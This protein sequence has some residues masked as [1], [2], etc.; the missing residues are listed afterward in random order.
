MIDRKGAT[1]PALALLLASYCI[2]STDAFSLT[3]IRIGVGNV[4]TC[5]SSYKTV[6]V[7]A[8]SSPLGA[9]RS[10]PFIIN[11]AQRS[12]TSTLLMAAEGE[13]YPAASD[14]EA[15]QS[16]FAKNCDGLMTEAELTSVPAIKEMLVRVTMLYI[17]LFNV[18]CMYAMG[19]CAERGL[20]VH[21]CF[22][23]NA[24]PNI[25]VHASSSH[26]AGARRSSLI[27]TRRNM[28]G[29]TQIPSRG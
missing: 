25:I 26:H 10:M 8:S 15:L 23:D 28:E 5:S 9:L 21:H 16:L 18:M 17:L 4:G 27:R 20:M 29:S 11:N 7:S 1:T 6:A 22:Y 14:G 13:E 19:V 3:N 24:N 12:S 2:G